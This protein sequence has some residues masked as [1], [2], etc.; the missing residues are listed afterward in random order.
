MSCGEITKWSERTEPR[1]LTRLNHHV[2]HGDMA[3]G[4]KSGGGAAKI[5]HRGE[6]SKG[7]TRISETKR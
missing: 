5:T 1:R 7:T 4:R 6:H 3:T 2:M